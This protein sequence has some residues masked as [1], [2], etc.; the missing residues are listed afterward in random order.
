MDVFELYFRDL[1]EEAQKRFLDFAKVEC[2]EDI[3]G[4]VYPI[5]TVSYDYTGQ[6]E[7][8]ETHGDDYGNRQ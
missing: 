7:E 5:A 4:D 6:D 1:T 8:P 2:I 3:N